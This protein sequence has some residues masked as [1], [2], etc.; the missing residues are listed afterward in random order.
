MA[1]ASS[2]FA[3]ALGGV[4]GVK[5]LTMTAPGLLPLLLLLTL[6]LAARPGGALAR[7]RGCGQGAQAACPEGCVEED[8]APP[9]ERCTEARGCLRKEGQHC[10]V[11]TPYCA[12]GLQCL[13]PKDDEA[14]LRALLLGRGSCREARAPSEEHPKESKPKQ[15]M[16]RRDQQRHPGTNSGGAQDTE[17][18]PCRRHLDTVLQQLQTEI[19]RGTQP[20]YVPNCDHRG[21]YRRRQCRSSQGQRRGPCWCVDRM[22]QPLPGTP[23]GNGSISCPSGSSG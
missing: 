21:F 17:M 9:A 11:Y 10:G 3:T 16:N 14:P 7:C 22:G 12:P 23:D 1:A 18:G 6:Q 13:P 15:D 4:D 5:I 2:R 20:L 19:F 8:G